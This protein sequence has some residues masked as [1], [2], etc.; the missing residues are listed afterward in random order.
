MKSTLSDLKIHFGCA[1][2]DYKDWSGPFYPNRLP[3]SNFLEHYAKF[4]DLAEINSTFYN[5]PQV[6]MVQNWGIRTPERFRFIVKMWQQITHGPKT[7]DDI[8]AG[9]YQFIDRIEVLREKTLAILIQFPPWFKF[10]EK[11]YKQ[12]QFLLS[13]ASREFKYVIEL[14]D[15]SWFS[16]GILKELIDGVQFILGTTYMPDIKAFYYSDQSF[17]Y[18]RLIGDREL[19]VFN[20][21]Q[22]S[23]EEAIADLEKKINQLRENSNIRE[24]FIIVNN[25]FAGFGPGTINLLRKR[26][27]LPTKDFNP[28]K[29]LTDFL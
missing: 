9:Y 17:Y 24:I 29:S 6:E 16:S 26:F 3:R 7:F 18:I 20:R 11:H 21:I 25:H 27:N 23:Q 22:R 1:G 8:E 5:L 12:L 19:T 4:F 14:R 28:Q 13:I 2:W 10:S 15:N